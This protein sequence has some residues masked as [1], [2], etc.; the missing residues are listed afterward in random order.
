MAKKKTRKL[1]NDRYNQSYSSKDQGG[2]SRRGILDFK[3]GGYEGVKW[4]KPNEGI[5]KIIIIP[6]EV[7]SDK[8]PL[9]KA[10]KLE[11][12]DLDYVLDVYVHKYVGPT[13]ADI[14]CPKETY[15]KPCPLCDLQRT[16]Y[17]NAKTEEEK[18]EA[19]ALKAKRRVLYNILPVVKGEIAE[20]ME[21]W[22]VSHFLFE[23]ELIEEANDCS[24]GQGIIPFAD[25]EAGSIIKFRTQVE[26]SKQFGETQK[27]KSFDFLEREEEL[28]DAIIDEAISFDECLVLLT[29]DEIMALYTGGDDDDDDEDKPQKTSRATSSRK[30]TTKKVEEED[31]DEEEE[32][33]EKPKRTSRISTRSRTK[34]APE[35]DEED[36]DEEEEEEE[37]KPSKTRAASRKSST[38]SKAKKEESNDEDE[39]E[40]EEEEKPVRKSIR[41]P[42]SRKKKQEPDPEDEDEDEE[43]EEPTDGECPSGH[44]F[45]E[46][47]DKF[48]K[49]CNRC[50]IW[51]ECFEASEG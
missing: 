36:E 1:S 14:L 49:D 11:V 34:K 46:D 37:K 42:V 18:E 5:N 7:K 15:G 35:P 38:R 22:D 10:G 51:E 16:L 44:V 24:D 3:A 23:K 25:I 32:E 4:F 39:E 26:K 19:K 2:V 9:V 13:G 47:C 28:D 45:G 41:K 6:F 33:E 40:D 12:G 50:P 43:D 8:H 27:Y 20:E 17:K 21:V 29:P 31:E 30:K 48:K